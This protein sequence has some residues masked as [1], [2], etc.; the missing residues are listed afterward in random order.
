MF[1]AKLIQQL[2][3]FS[4]YKF[5]YTTRSYRGNTLVLNLYLSSVFGDVSITK[6]PKSCFVYIWKFLRG[7]ENFRNKAVDSVLSPARHQRQSS[8]ILSTQA[9]S[10]HVKKFSRELNSKSEIFPYYFLI[11]KQSKVNSILASLFLAYM[12]IT[13]I[14]NT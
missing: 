1:Q 7:V 5:E 11:I 12:R 14:E 3:H 6:Y 13:K 4:S 8:L 10:P 2:K 9:K